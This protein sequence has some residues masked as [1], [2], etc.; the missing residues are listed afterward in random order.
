[1]CRPA[2]RSPAA[3][4]RGAASRSRTAASAGRP[5]TASSRARRAPRWR[6]N[7][8]SATTPV[9]RARYQSALGPIAP[10][11]TQRAH[12]TGRR[13]ARASRPRWRAAPYDVD[14]PAGQPQELQPLE[15]QLAAH[16]RRGAGDVRVQAGA[17]GD[18]DRAVDAGR[19]RA[20]VG[21]DQV[22]GEAAVVLPPAGDRARR[23]QPARAQR[24]PL[25]R[26]LG[27][28]AVVVG[29]PDR[30]AAG[31]RRT[32]DR[33]VAAE[34]DQHP[35]PRGP[36][37]RR[38]RGR[39][40]APWRSRR[41]RATRRG[42]AGRCRRRRRPRRCAS[43]YRDDRHATAPASR[44]RRHSRGH[45]RARSAPG[46]TVGSTSPSVSRAARSDCLDGLQQDRPDGDRG[47]RAG[48][49]R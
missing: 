4:R 13:P 14:Q 42:R 31:R 43:R 7:S 8:T 23:G 22:V 30:P 2:A 37:P 16:D 45:S 44:S 49:D 34:R 33:D 18:S 5:R 19:G 11:T 41:G 15:R 25:A 36:V 40:P 29:D 20:R 21:V 9:L 3:R 27:V 32:G 39:R 6:V 28:G 1:M 12:A 48:V 35:A 46:P 47:T 10:G 38:R 17:G 24:D 26:R